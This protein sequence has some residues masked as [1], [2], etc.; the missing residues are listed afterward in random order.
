MTAIENAISLERG[1]FK[2][3]LLVGLYNGHTEAAALRRLLSLQK[4]AGSCLEVKVARNPRFHW[5]VYLFNTERHF[6]VYVGS[7]NLT[8]D[9]LGTEGE[10]NLRISGMVADRPLRNISETFD[11]AWR[12][13][14]VPLTEKISDNFAPISQRSLQLSKQIDPNIRKVLRTIS[15]P[16]TKAREPR[17]R[18]SSVFTFVEEFAGPSTKKEVRKKQRW[19]AKGWEWMVFRTR[20]ARDRLFK[21]GSFYLAEIHR[22]GGV[23]SFR[24]VCEEDEFGTEDGRFFVA[25]QKRR[26]SVARRLNKRT[27]KLLKDG[28]LIVKKDDLCQDRRVGKANRDLLN[29]LLRVSN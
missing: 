2:V 24:D 15:R 18:H 4:R 3:K 16:K 19:D 21:A 1:G 6:T 28:G 8:R 25:Y 22:A 9:G 14:A 10:F 20:A 11:R 26:G 7:S 13:D 27:L 5:K 17:T 12:R 29:R 23:I